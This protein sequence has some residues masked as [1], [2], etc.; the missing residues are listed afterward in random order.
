MARLD[1]EAEMKTHYEQVPLE[2]VKKI[3]EAE[4]GPEKKRQPAR[5][6]RKK[7][8]KQALWGLSSMRVRGAII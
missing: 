1:C 6:A 2:V 4:R 3:P 5:R 7:A 8:P